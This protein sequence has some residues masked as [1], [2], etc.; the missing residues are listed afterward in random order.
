MSEITVAEVRTVLN[1]ALTVND[2]EIQDRID[3]AEAEYAEYVI[4]VVNSSI[5]PGTS[6]TKKFHGG[7]ESIVLGPPSVAS[8][9]A[10]GYVDG[11][12]I[13]TV[14]LDLDTNTGIVYWDY[15]T[16]G[17]FT[18]GRRNVVLTFTLG[19]LPKNHRS[20]IVHDVAQLFALTQR[21]PAGLPGEDL[22][23]QAAGA[24]PLTLFPRIRALAVPS[25]A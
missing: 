17:W 13:T 24:A 3:E 5:E 22:Y 7:G 9:T 21:G 14:D 1:K 25:I 8:V 19:E 11:T 20:A 16:T 4:G 15:G 12:T 2:A 10:A 23:E 18:S 6:V